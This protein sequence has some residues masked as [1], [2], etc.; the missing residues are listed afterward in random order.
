LR[1]LAVREI[2]ILIPAPIW[3]KLEVIERKIGMTKEDL[4]MRAIVKIIEELGEG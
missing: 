4:I 3:D 1:K 2:K